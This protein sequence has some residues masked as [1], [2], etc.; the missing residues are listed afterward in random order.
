MKLQVVVSSEHDS[1]AVPEA[2]QS[3]FQHAGADLESHRGWDPGSHEITE[4]LKEILK[5]R[6]FVYPYTRLLIEPNR[7]L[8]NGDLFSEYSRKLSAGERDS[9]IRTFYLPHRDQVESEIERL[10]IG[11]PVLHLGVHTFTPHWKG[12]KREVDIGILFDPGRQY[13]GQFAH[14]LMSNLSGKG[15][16]VREN[17]PYLGIADGFTTYLRGRFADEKYMG[18]ELEVSQGLLNRLDQVNAILGE[19]LLKAIGEFEDQVLLQR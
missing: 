14:Q 19:G 3:L 8:D 18:F 5:V 2:Y 16:T 12:Q 15:F 7:S 9:L 11:G 17:E 10:S 4:Y 13:E 6:P 1:N